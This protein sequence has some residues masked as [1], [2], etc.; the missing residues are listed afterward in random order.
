MKT[1]IDQDRI[2][3]VAQPG[4]VAPGRLEFLRGASNVTIAGDPSLTDL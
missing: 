1:A 2:S 3:S 4:P